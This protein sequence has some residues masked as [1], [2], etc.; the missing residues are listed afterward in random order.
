MSKNHLWKKIR[1]Q[2]APHLGEDFWNDISGIIPAQGPRVDVFR[3]NQLITILVELPGLN[4]S[5]QLKLFIEDH[6]LHIKGEVPYPYPVSQDELMVSERFFGH[7]H[8]KI[9]LPSDIVYEGIHAVYQNGLLIVKV[10][11]KIAEHKSIPIDIHFNA[12]RTEEEM[13]HG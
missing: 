2:A 7:F 4:H 10:A 5:E 9:E 8:R 3:E 13:D 12:E 11:I 6:T 1:A